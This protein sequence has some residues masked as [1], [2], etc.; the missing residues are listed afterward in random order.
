M[1]LYP[2]VPSIIKIGIFI[3]KNCWTRIGFAR[4]FRVDQACFFL[5]KNASSIDLYN[6]GLNGVP[7]LS[8]MYKRFFVKYGDVVTEY[9]YL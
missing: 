7:M 8:K 2:F 4:R 6:I 5:Y 9:L 1:V 3:G